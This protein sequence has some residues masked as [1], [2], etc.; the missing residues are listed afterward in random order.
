MNVF[1]NIFLL[2]IQH[3]FHIGPGWFMLVVDQYRHAVLENKL[4]HQHSRFPC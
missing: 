3:K 4:V 2:K 1:S